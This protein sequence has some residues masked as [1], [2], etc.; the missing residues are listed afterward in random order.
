MDTGGVTARTIEFYE[1]VLNRYMAYTGNRDMSESANQLI[2]YFTLMREDNLSDSTIHAQLRGLRAFYKFCTEYG[3]VD[4][5]PKLPRVKTPKESPEPLSDDELSRCLLYLDRRKGFDARRNGAIF[6]F[7]VDTGVRLRECVGIDVADVLWSERKFRVIRKG[8][9][10]QWLPY[11]RKVQR[12]LRDYM[13]HRAR[14]VNPHEQSFWIAITGG[15]LKA[16][17]L[18][19]V[20]RRMSD[21]LDIHIHPHRLR[22]TF[23]VNWIMNGGD[24]FTLQTLLGHESQHMVSRYVKIVGANVSTQHDRFSPIDRT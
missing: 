17:S 24:P 5:M 22:H 14:Y 18:Q 21:R 23:A 15:R 12:A 20:F 13:A 8:G 2:P 3:Y 7:M 11:G 6:R 9:K 1:Y 19:T 4:E 10:E 16:H